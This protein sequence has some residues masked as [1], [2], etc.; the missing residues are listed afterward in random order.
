MS[1]RDRPPT[2]RERAQRRATLRPHPLR[3]QIL[4]LM[5][6]YGHPI[7]PTQAARIA[8][9]SLGS[10]AYHFRMLMEAGVIELVDEGR[11]RGAVEHLYALV[12]DDELHLVDPV[13]RALALAGVLTMP[14]VNGGYPAPT[15]LDGRALAELDTLLNGFRK[16]VRRIALDSAKRAS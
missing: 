5:V 8:G 7:S 3:D 1:R 9:S 14:D 13:Q 11:V 4:D 10:T 12:S 16:G 2:R 15:V 6:S